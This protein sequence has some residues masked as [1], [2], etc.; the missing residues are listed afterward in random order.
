MP[1]I[2]LVVLCVLGGCSFEANYAEGTFRCADKSQTCP[3]PLVCE[4]NLDNDFVCRERRMD[5]AVDGSGDGSMGD[6]APGH[7]LNCDDPQ[8]LV[9]GEAFV[10]STDLR[11]NKLSTACANRTML[12]FDTVHVITPGAGK[13]MNVTVD[14]AQAATAYVLSACPQT[15]CNGNVYATPDNPATVYTLAGPHYIVVDSLAS[16]VHGAYTLTV[17]Y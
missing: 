11:S 4:K 17:S 2:A 16:N 12:G 7:L 8:P 9:N 1:R 14:A 3:S 15:A 10:G 6:A 13:N 5:A